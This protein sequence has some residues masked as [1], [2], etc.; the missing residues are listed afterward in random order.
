[1]V[2]IDPQHVVVNATPERL[3]ALGVAAQEFVDAACGRIAC[4]PAVERATVQGLGLDTMDATEYLLHALF[5]VVRRMP[6]EFLGLDEVH[7]RVSA[8]PPI[9]CSA[10][11]QRWCRGSA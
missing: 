10:R 6:H 8:L 9:W 11:C 2:R 1:M 3:A 7:R 5:E 4:V